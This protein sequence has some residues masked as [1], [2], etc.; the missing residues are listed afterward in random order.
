VALPLLG[1]VFELY[2]GGCLM[3]LGTHGA[4]LDGGIAFVRDLP[5]TWKLAQRRLP[6]VA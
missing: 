5:T 3:G 4:K 2:N 1:V 6:E